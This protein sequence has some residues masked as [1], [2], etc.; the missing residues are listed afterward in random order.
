MQHHGVVVFVPEREA[1]VLVLD[2]GPLDLLGALG[3]AMETH[4]LLDVLGGPVQTDVEEV[5]LVLR[6]GDSGQRPDLGVAE[7]SLRKRLGELLRIR[8]CRVHAAQSF[9]YTERVRLWA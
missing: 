9:R 6:R 2:I 5:V 4:E 1:A 3:P 7:L 8:T